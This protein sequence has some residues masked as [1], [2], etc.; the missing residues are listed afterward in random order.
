MDDA[1]ITCSPAEN[2][3]RPHGGP[4]DKKLAKGDLILFDIGAK[5]HGYTSDVTRVS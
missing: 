4:V 1:I 2:A 5:L 3:A